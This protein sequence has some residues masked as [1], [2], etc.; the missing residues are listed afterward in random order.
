[1]NDVAIKKT[2]MVKDPGFSCILMGRQHDVNVDSCLSDRLLFLRAHLSSRPKL[3]CNRQNNRWKKVE[4]C[5]IL[6][7]FSFTHLYLRRLSYFYFLKM[8]ALIFAFNL[9][10]YIRSCIYFVFVCV[11]VCERERERER[12]REREVGRER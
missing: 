3:T 2:A 5:Y 12:G 11:C 1:M 9:L 8:S 7:L 4:V 6:F 10:N